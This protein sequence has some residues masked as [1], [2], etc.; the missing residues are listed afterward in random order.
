MPI[1]CPPSHLVLRYQ[2]ELTAEFDWPNGCGVESKED[3]TTVTG[4]RSASN[5]PGA[6]LSA[7]RQPSFEHTCGH[8][9]HLNRIHAYVKVDIQSDTRC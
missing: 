6:L 8:V 9:R 2:M 5:T 1:I 3:R 4:A 7:T